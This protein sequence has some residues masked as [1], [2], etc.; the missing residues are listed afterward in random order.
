MKQQ[1]KCI[2]QGEK[3]NEVK[4]PS[5]SRH[6]RG[7]KNYPKNEEDSTWTAPKGITTRLKSK[8]KRLTELLSSPVSAALTPDQGAM[9][10]DRALALMAWAQDNFFSVE[11]LK[12]E[13][14]DVE[15][16]NLDLKKKLESKTMEISNLHNSLSESKDQ[17]K[18]LRCTINELTI[19]LSVTQTARGEKIHRKWWQFWKC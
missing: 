13:K 5:S 18:E 1:E 11:N 7:S 10:F 3:R 16:S 14:R 9:D 12:K 2:S 19:L 17:I 4:N 15:N 6:A 8:Q